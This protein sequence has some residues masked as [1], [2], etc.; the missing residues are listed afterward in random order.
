MAGRPPKPAAVKR[1]EGNPGK[2]KI[3]KEPALNGAKPRCPG[4]ISDDAKKEW[5]RVVNDLYD[6]GL[7][8]KADSTVL[9][10][11][12]EAYSEF[13]RSIEAIEKDGRITISPN[14][15]PQKSAWVTIRDKAFDHMIKCLTEMGMT[16]VSRARVAAREASALDPF[17]EWI[18]HK[19][20]QKGS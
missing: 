2:R 11:Y 14:G 6:S 18:K 19:N 12:C 3:P 20:M 5:R 15:Y 16:P 17:D 10:L 9:A 4:F 7:L 13:I 8:V 1:A